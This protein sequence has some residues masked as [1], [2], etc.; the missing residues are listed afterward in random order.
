MDE[1]LIKIKYRNLLN[2]LYRIKSKYKE[3]ENTYDDLNSCIKENLVVDDKNI[4]ENNFSFIKNTSNA[5]K[6]ELVN[7]IIPIVRSRS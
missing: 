7:N 5:L 2:K 1:E 4:V 6:D 3:L